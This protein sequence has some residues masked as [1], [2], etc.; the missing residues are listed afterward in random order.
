[1]VEEVAA[2]EAVVAIRNAI[3]MPMST[4]EVGFQRNW[5]FLARCCRADDEIY[6]KSNQYIKLIPLLKAGNREYANIPQAPSYCMTI[7][8]RR[9]WWNMSGVQFGILCKQY[10]QTGACVCIRSREHIRGNTRVLLR[11]GRKT[12]LGTHRKR[13]NGKMMINRRARY[14][15]RE[16]PRLCRWT[17]AI[18]NY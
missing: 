3:R 18:M 4:K 14:L 12:L 2:P 6:F 7:Y 5:H 9:V 11:I 1:M 15:R 13:R 17:E 8:S 16:N 10:L